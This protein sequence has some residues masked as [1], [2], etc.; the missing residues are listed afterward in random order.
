MDLFDL[1][2][3]ETDC[4][5]CGCAVGPSR[6]VDSLYAKGRNTTINGESQIPISQQLSSTSII[7][8]YCLQL[9]P[10][11]NSQCF[12]CGLPLSASPSDK[13]NQENSMG[14]CGACL[15]NSPKYDR[16]ISAFHYQDPINEFITQLKY[17]AKLQ[18]LKLL[19]DS[20]IARL[21]TS[22]REQEWPALLIPVPLHKKKLTKRGFNQSRLLANQ[23]AK[24]LKI[25]VLKSG[26]KRT[27]NTQA[28][29]GLDSI[30]RKLNMKDAFRISEKLPNHIAIVD[31]V[32]TTG[33]TVS[34]LTKQARLAGA[35][36]VDVWCIARAYED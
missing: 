27:K 26:I 20:L 35:K 32:V 4:Y 15:S 12:T 31:D 9:L 1:I 33:M 8:E 10:F 24:S 13:L 36:K 3:I 25:P 22:Y 17:A 34:E 28:Q 6:H 23:L 30:E 2:S 21:S 5:L 7:C 18:L 19:S 29:S 16:L 11:S 14:S